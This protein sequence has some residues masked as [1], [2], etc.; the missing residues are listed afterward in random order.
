MTTNPQIEWKL[1]TFLKARQI[2]TY[3][4]EQTLK[5][6]V[7]RNTVYKWGRG[8]PKCVETNALGLVI[9][10]LRI[11]TDEPVTVGDILE[12]TPSGE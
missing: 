4:L 8:A 12:F 7:S 5:G 10:A 1:P 9:E 3:K 2:T 11:L 6:K